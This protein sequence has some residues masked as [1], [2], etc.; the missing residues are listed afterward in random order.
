V[1]SEIIMEREKKICT[2]STLH[3]LISVRSCGGRMGKNKITNSIKP[4][5]PGMNQ[6]EQA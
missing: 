5:N 4:K 2:R 1:E 3:E 6:E